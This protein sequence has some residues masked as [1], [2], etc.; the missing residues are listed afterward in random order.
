MGCQQRGE[1][2]CI[3]AE[4]GYREEG[5]E[6]SLYVRTQVMIDIW[7]KALENIEEAQTRPKNTMMQSNQK[8]SH[9]IRL[10]LWCL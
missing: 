2:K 8:T 4:V 9:A 7:K 10:E 6:D 3:V 5:L 1:E